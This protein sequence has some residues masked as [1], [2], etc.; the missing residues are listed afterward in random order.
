MDETRSMNL[1]EYSRQA[2]GDA[3][4]AGQI[5]RLPRA[6]LKNQIERL[7]ARVRQ[8]KDRP[9]FVTRDRKR[10]GCPCR[11][12][13]RC[14]REFVFEPAKTLRRGLFFRERYCQDGRRVAAL[15]AAVKSEVRAFPEQF[16]HVPGRL[17]DR[18]HARRHGCTTSSTRLT[19]F[20][21]RELNVPGGAP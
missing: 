8:Y 14:V 12:E 18:R 6:S 9:S 5:E 1:P 15:P 4:D 13:F 3:Q 16:Q 20:G 2:T 17:C 11:I 19:A 7:T 10:L 21:P